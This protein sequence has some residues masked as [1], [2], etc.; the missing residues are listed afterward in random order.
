MANHSVAVQK[1][2]KFRLRLWASHT[3]AI[4]AE[5]SFP[6]KR[7]YF[8][9]PA[10]AVHVLELHST[11][12]S[13]LRSSMI[14]SSSRTTAAKR[15]LRG[16]SR[17]VGNRRQSTLLS[18]N[19]RLG[20]TVASAVRQNKWRAPVMEYSTEQ[21]LKLRG[22]TVSHDS[23]LLYDAT[24]EKDNC[25]VGLI[26]NLKSIPSRRV[27]DVADEMLVRM[28]H[29]GGVGCD[30]CSGDGAGKFADLDLMAAAEN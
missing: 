11:V 12:N 3:A 30:P 19:R 13:Q 4:S 15:V 20:R 29:R 23:K 10:A 1:N 21:I 8:A 14:S 2:A 9:S 27:V 16:N 26:A 7:S 25:G 5:L 18:G 17:V 22:A 24:Q 28:A 6:R